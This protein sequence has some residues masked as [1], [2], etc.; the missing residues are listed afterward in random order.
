MLVTA[1][2]ILFSSFSR[3]NSHCLTRPFPAVH[4]RPYTPLFISFGFGF[5]T[6]QPHGHVGFFFSFT[7]N[8]SLP[9]SFFLFSVPVALCPFPQT[10]PPGV[11]QVVCFLFP[12][13]GLSSVFFRPA[14]V[15]FPLGGPTFGSGCGLLFLIPSITVGSFLS[16]PEGN[17]LALFLVSA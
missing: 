15:E 11:P 14:R 10:P 1:I 12:P 16:L 4:L 9:S 3:P 6:C 13:K 5:Q 2:S 7:M 17:L 8:L